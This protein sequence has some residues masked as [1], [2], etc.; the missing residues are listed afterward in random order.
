MS[1]DKW[2]GA[3]TVT[4]RVQAKGDPPHFFPGFFIRIDP[5][6]PHMSL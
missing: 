2:I 6:K 3:V 1:H 5:P 4:V